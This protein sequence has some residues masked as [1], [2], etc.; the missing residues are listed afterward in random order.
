M[1]AAF[2]IVVVLAILSNAMFAVMDFTRAK[3]VLA[4]SREV[5]VP[6]SWLP[7][8]GAL[9]GAGALGLLLGLIGINGVGIAAALGLTAFFTG[10]IV[11]HIRA[12]VFHNIAFPGAF[13][14]LAA[15]SLL[16]TWPD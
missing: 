10:A 7:T 12:G 5:G 14:L 15:L 4:N 1:H 8:L 6:L 2:T 9:K 13:F 16:G 11:T 3:F